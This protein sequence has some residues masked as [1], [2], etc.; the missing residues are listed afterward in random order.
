MSTD[1]RPSP[2][3]RTATPELVRAAVMALLQTGGWPGVTHAAVAAHAGVHRAT[4]YR[5]WPSRADLLLEAIT[6]AASRQ[7]DAEATDDPR[8][9]LA[10]LLRRTADGVTRYRVVIDALLGARAESDEVNVVVGQWFDAREAGF[11]AL[12]AHHAD[13]LP[14]VPDHVP[15]AFTLGM[16]AVWGQLVLRRRPA[17]SLD[18]DAVAATLVQALTTPTTST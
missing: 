4:V 10:A 16:G 6:D 7:I 9:D 15:H 18:A 1:P 11:G 8:R 3:R 5:R 12:L 14:G 13:R 2:T 17:S